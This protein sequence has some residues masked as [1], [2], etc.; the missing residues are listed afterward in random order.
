MRDPAGRGSSSGVRKHSEDT[1]GEYFYRASMTQCSIPASVPRCGLFSCFAA[2]DR[3]RT[4][5][6]SFIRLGKIKA[7]HRTSGTNC[8]RNCWAK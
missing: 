6:L 5:A 4:N 3:R 7:R 2:A 8:V 1:L